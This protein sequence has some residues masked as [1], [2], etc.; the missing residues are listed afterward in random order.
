MDPG[1]VVNADSAP[2]RILVAAT[3]PSLRAGLRAMLDSSPLLSVVGELGHAPERG[4]VDFSAVDVLVADVPDESSLRGHLKMAQAAVFLASDPATFAVLRGQPSPPRALLLQ[5]ASSDEL[6][7]AVLAVAAGLVVMDPAVAA[8]WDNFGAGGAGE[9]HPAPASPLTA[10]E[11]AVLGLV[12]LGLPNKTIALRLSISEHTVKFH[13][14]AIL[15]KLGAA[16]RTEAVT[17]AVRSGLLP[18]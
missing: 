11:Q 10:R 8:A 1:A 14:G 17:L 5:G 18:L 15:G 6:V 9:A 3:Y 12:A 7:A 16:S 13:V 2:I 4:E